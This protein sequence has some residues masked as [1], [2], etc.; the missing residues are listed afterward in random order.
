MPELG[1]ELCARAPDG[2]AAR[3]RIASS[4]RRLAH[5]P[6]GL[7]LPPTPAGA[8]ERGDLGPP[9]RERRLGLREL[10]RRP[11][12]DSFLR[13][14]ASTRTLTV[15]AA[16]LRTFHA[17]D[18]SPRSERPNIRCS[19]ASAMGREWWTRLAPTPTGLSAP[20]DDRRLERT[21]TGETPSRDTA[22]CL[23]EEVHSEEDESP[24][25]GNHHEHHQR[26]EENPL[27][28]PIRCLD[29]RPCSHPFPLQ[30]ST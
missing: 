30:A 26:D 7:P 24:C 3:S 27:K 4:P 23:L 14:A 17:R 15:D 21:P 2:C 8:G 29:D 20:K 19:I 1:G 10:H 18:A 12:S 13:S 9:E 28:A 16:P 22:S 25:P 6:P 5:Q 11:C